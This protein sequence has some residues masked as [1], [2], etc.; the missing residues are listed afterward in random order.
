M[1]ICMIIVAAICIFSITA[2]AEDNCETRYLDLLDR[3]TNSIELSD[4]D[5]A[6][7]IPPL[8]TALQLCKEGKKKQ[9]S[10][11]VEELRHEKALKT[12]FSSYDGN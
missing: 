5:K 8:Q 6:E 12:V 11:I 1:K 9:A 7:F 10:K 4:A 3:V 2:Y